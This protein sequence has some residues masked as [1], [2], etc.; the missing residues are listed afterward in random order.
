MS[1]KVSVEVQSVTTVEEFDAL[2][3]RMKISHP[4]K[5]AARVASGDLDR[6]R[7]KLIQKVEEKP[8]DPSE[9]AELTKKELIEEAV[10]KGIALTGTESKAELKELLK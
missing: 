4:L 2:V 3:A 6:Q 9:P 5:H 10:K 1:I 7:S 8:V